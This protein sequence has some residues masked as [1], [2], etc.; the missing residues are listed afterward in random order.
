MFDTGCY[1]ELRAHKRVQTAKPARVSIDAS[2]HDCT[3]RD[4]SGGG[5]FVE[6]EA[7][8]AIGTPVVLCDEDWGIMAATVSRIYRRGFA[9]A[10]GVSETAKQKLIDR[11]TV[12]L[13][14]QELS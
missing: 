8:A 13:N 6:V 12:Y 9:V 1:T 4:I 14:K 7:P 3:I 5:A 2:W 11:L 10:F